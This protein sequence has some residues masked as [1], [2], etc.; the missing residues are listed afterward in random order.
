MQ[1]IFDTGD[2]K[3]KHQ[4]RSLELDRITSGMSANTPE[5]QHAKWHIARRHGLT[6]SQ[7]AAVLGASKWETPFTIWAYQTGRNNAD[8]QVKAAFEWGH[9]LE[10]VIAQKYMDDFGVQ[11]AEYPTIQSPEYPFL[12]GSVDRIVLDKNGKPVKVLEIKT[13]SFNRDSGEKDDDGTSLKQWGK[14]NVYNAQG[15][16]IEQDSQ[17]PKQYLLQVMHYMILTGLKQADIAVLLNTNDYRVFTIDYDEELAAEMIKAADE[18]WCHH[19]LDDVMPM[20]K[21]SDAKTITPTKG[22]TVQATDKVVK[23]IQVYNELKQ[24]IDNL[25]K[26]QQE[27]RDFI[28]GF[29]GTNEALID[30]DENTIATYN[31]CKGKVG[32]NSKQFKLDYPEIYAKYVT[33]GAPYRRL[34]FR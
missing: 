17:V 24:S 25:T 32:F 31:Q 4:Q 19:V 1:L 10:P 16:L 5:Q 23:A 7:I 33:A 2:Y 11:V 22:A 34:V 18:F 6:G 30:A 3:A 20:L 29:I 8:D 13:S 28:T 9:R 27:V 15:Q 14:G 21:E 26:R 12:V